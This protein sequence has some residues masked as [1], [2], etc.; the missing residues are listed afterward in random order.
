MVNGATLKIHIKSKFDRTHL[1]GDIHHKDMYVYVS[2][3]I[4]KMKNFFLAIFDVILV[5][6]AIAFG[7]W[8]NFL[9]TSKICKKSKCDTQNK[10]MF[11][12][13]NKL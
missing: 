13:Q 12:Y 3:K 8:P 9:A 7:H 5:L 1:K 10:G 11:M 4:I 6:K 2:E